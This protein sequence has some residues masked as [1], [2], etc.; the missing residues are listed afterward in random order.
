LHS[1]HGKLRQKGYFFLSFFFFLVCF[2]PGSHEIHC[3]AVNSDA[4]LLATAH[5]NGDACVWRLDGPQPQLLH[6]LAHDKTLRHVALHARTLVACPGVMRSSARAMVI[7]NNKNKRKKKG[8]KSTKARCQATG[9]RTN[10]QLDEGA[11]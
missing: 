9:E 1:W 10:E 7:F 8:K 3:I 2:G 6:T 11:L 4:S 5:E